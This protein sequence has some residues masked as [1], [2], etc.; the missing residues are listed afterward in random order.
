MSW[1]DYAKQVQGAGHTRH[2]RDASP[3]LPNTVPNVPSVPPCPPLDAGRA[4]RQCKAALARMDWDTPPEGFTGA[5][6]SQL[7]RDAHWLLDHF[8]GQALRDG[9]TVGELFGRWPEKDTWGGIADRL[10]SSRSLMMTADRAH[11]RCARTG[12]PMQ[13][14]RTAYP[15]LRPF[16][17]TVA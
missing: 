2:I 14:N 1:R 3:D 5:R 9:W 15:D 12:D 11:W 7:L 4:T 13:F 8:A 6:W 10:R 17:E 16:W